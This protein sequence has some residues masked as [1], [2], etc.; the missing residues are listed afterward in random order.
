MTT[1]K[2]ESFTNAVMEYLDIANQ[3][4]IRLM[5]IQNHLTSILGLTPRQAKECT[6]WW[7]AMNGK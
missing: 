3:L 2:P 4:K 6:R 5:D 1:D 7:Y